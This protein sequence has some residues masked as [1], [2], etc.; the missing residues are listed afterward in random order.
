ME[1][2]RWYLEI[3]VSINYCCGPWRPVLLRNRTELID[4]V[5]IVRF[6]TRKQL[7]HQHR[8]HYFNRDF[9]E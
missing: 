8:A 9:D 2:M 1:E 4:S 3:G 6:M 7:C 5:I